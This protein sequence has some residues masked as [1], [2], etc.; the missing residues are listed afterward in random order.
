M[1]LSA[2]LDEGQSAE[3]LQAL[4]QGLHGLMPASRR[5]I[6]PW[7]HLFPRTSSWLLPAGL[8]G[9]LLLPATLSAPVHEI[10]VAEE[11][12]LH[13]LHLLY[14]F[15]GW[16]LDAEWHQRGCGDVHSLMP[17]ASEER[18]SG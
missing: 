8:S 12:F 18:S 4:M 1:L 14:G 16:S 7:M 5:G 11:S 9:I 3:C 15:L 6:G 17:R 2:S 10:P 13:L